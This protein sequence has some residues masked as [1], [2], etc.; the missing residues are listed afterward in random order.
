MEGVP[1]TIGELY[2]TVVPY[3]AVRGTLGFAELAAYEHTLLRMLAGERDYV[4]I[5]RE[6]VQEELQRELRSPNPILGVYRDYADVGTHVNPNIQVRTDPSPTVPVP[7][8]PAAATPAPP[9]STA[10]PLD[11]WPGVVG[12]PRTSASGAAPPA[13]RREAPVA[14]AKPACPGCRSTLPEGRDARFCPFCGKALKPVP[15]ASCGAAVEAE[16]SFCLECG[17]PRPAPGTPPRAPDA[18]P[19]QPGR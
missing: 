6:G 11:G 9:P 10:R 5:D 8:P 2:Q 3:R 14:P 7:R 19:P 16:W 1:V 17:G 18:R 4:S 13:P 12:S 15:C